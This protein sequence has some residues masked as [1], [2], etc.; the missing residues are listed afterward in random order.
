MCEKIFMDRD[1]HGFFKLP[2]IVVGEIPTVSLHLA[3]K[4]NLTKVEQVLI[5][6]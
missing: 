4:E 2:K 3:E 1:E 5:C 6:Q